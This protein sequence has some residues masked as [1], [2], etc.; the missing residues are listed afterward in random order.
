MR[1]AREILDGQMGL[2]GNVHPVFVLE[3][4][5]TSEVTEHTRQC[6]A[7]AQG[8]GFM[9][10]PGCDLSA[11]TPEENVAAFVRAGHEWVA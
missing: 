9:L 3:E 5:S 6:L 7:E 2:A 10:L 4:L 1:K 11:K 8:V